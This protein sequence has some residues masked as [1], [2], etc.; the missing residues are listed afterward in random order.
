MITGSNTTVEVGNANID[1]GY[2]HDIYIYVC[3]CV[4]VCVRALARLCVVCMY[5][6]AVHNKAQGQI[7]SNCEFKL[8]TF[9][10][11]TES[12]VA[13]HLQPWSLGVEHPSQ[14]RTV[15]RM[16]SLMFV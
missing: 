11:G 7:I 10:Q 15:L 14:I 1:L 16:F 6:L 12:R 13:N 3:V 4:C 5:V 9:L 2:I 8:W